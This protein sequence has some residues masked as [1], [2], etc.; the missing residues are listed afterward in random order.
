MHSWSQLTSLGLALTGMI[1]ALWPT[2]AYLGTNAPP[3]EGRSASAFRRLLKFP[4]F[5]LGLALLAYL[6]TQALNP[7][8]R[9][10][11]NGTHWWLVRVPNLAWLPTSVDVPFARFNVWRQFIIY[12]SAW[13]T[14]CTVAIGLTRRRSFGILLAALAA[15]GLLLALAGFAM[16]ALRS[17]ERILWLEERFRGSVTF[18]SFIYK[19]HASAY[20]ALIAV[21]LLVLAARYRERALREHATSSPALLPVLGSL[22]MLFAVIFTYSRGGTLLLGAYLLVAA[23]AFAV[24]RA[25]TGT[26]SSTPRV[27]TFTI[28]AMVA[29]VV[30]F[31]LAQVNFARVMDRF[32]RLADSEH[33]DTSVSSRIDAHAAGRDM[34]SN[35]W[36]RGVGAGGFRHLFPEYI[37]RFAASYRGGLLFWEHAHNDWLEIPIELGLAGSA[38]ILGG[39]CWLAW[40]LARKSMVRS[41]P[42]LLLTI[43]LLQTLVH[44]SIDFPFQ[45]PAILIT[46][47]VLAVVA[48]RYLQTEGGEKT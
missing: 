36:P 38:L 25:L 16:R 15:N 1:A 34:L 20:L 32:E 44:A 12:A 42:V 28:G 46:W 10:A 21:V 5:W 14:L 26:Q 22:V 31:A 41:L 11:T 35:T 39:G 17:N 47:L 8:W 40:R 7:A 19:N 43:G 2:E 45:N 6:A 4:P 24:H 29:F 48:V 18:A 23:T 9:Y 37:R 33:Q 27:V 13:L 3:A 30:V